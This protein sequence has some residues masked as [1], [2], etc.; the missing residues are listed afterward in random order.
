LAA[1]MP[2]CRALTYSSP[3]IRR[4]GRHGP[5]EAAERIRSVTEKGDANRRHREAQE[6]LQITVPGLESSL[7]HLLVPRSD[8]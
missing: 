6:S 2:G 7:R 3:A 1:V 8:P 4:R 5:F